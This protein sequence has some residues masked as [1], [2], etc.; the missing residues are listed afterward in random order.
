MKWSIFAIVVL[1]LTLN[2]YGAVLLDLGMELFEGD[3]ASRLSLQFAN[4]IMSTTAVLLLIV[5][6][7]EKK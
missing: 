4:G 1:F 5:Q 6:R 7:F 2:L 3:E